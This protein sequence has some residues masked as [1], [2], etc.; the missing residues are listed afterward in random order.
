MLEFIKIR[1]N[2]FVAKCRKICDGLHPG[3]RISCHELAHRAI[4]GGAPSYYV[5]FDYAYRMLRS[6]RHNRLPPNYNPLKRLMWT[7]IADKTD[8]YKR[9]MGIK[10]DTEALAIVLARN[11]AS[12]FFFTTDYAIR[13]LQQLNHD[14]KIK[15]NAPLLLVPYRLGL[16]H[17]S[18]QLTQHT[19][20]RRG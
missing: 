1:D 8:N 11:C 12:R 7:E 5:T 14:H 6:L 9:Q 10:T 2:D 19:M 16:Q 20:L 15:H 13:L 4:S 18:P 17:K 3:E